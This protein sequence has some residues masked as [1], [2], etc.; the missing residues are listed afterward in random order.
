[1][2]LLFVLI[3]SCSLLLDVRPPIAGTQRLDHYD[4]YGAIRW[5]DEKAR[6]DNFAIQLQNDKTLVGYILVAAAL[7]GCPGE[8]QARAIRAKRYVVEHRGVPANRVIWRFEGYSSDLRTVVL[9]LSRGVV[10]PYP[11]LFTVPGKDGPLT[12][13]CKIKL[14]RIAKPLVASAKLQTGLTDS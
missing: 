13:Q 11:F 3:I 9:P 8:A 10:P 12:K 2:K 6:L 5:E 1:M 14:R 4:D 7:G